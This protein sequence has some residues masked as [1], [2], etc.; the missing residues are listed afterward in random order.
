MFGLTTKETFHEIFLSG[1][2][3]FFARTHG[4]SVKVLTDFMATRF[5]HM[6]EGDF[7]L[8]SVVFFHPT[9][10]TKQK[11]MLVQLLSEESL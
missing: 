3:I 8:I 10:Q 9:T 5:T 11:I 6:G 7:F 2:V 1:Q 4:E